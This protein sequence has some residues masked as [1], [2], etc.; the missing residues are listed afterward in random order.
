MW[1]GCRGCTGLHSDAFGCAGA[2]LSF[3]EYQ[4]SM[5]PFTMESKLKEV[6]G[7]VLYRPGVGRVRAHRV[8]P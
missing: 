6:D 3:E 4:D 8:L 1:D 5:G 7:T 2:Q